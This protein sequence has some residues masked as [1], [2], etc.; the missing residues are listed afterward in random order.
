MEEEGRWG[1][2]GG[3]VGA[4]RVGEERR[5]GTEM[6][7]GVVCR[8]REARKRGHALRRWVCAA[9]RCCDGCGHIRI[10]GEMMSSVG[11]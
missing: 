11:L 10:R 9:L 6:A 3:E 5:R 4:R 2:G 8:G 1:G 7:E